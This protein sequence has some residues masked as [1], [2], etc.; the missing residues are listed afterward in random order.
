VP[1]PDARRA[2][3]KKYY[4]Q[5]APTYDSNRYG[6]D[7]QRR[8]DEQAKSVVLE[9]LGDRDIAASRVL[10]C[11]CGTGRFTQLF[12][13]L[14]SEVVG[15][16]ASPQMIDIARKKVPKASFQLGDIFELPFKKEFDI[17]VSSQV[18]T[19]L[20]EYQ[21][22]LDGMLRA[23]RPG[24]TIV[25]DVRN[26]LSPRHALRALR[27]RA[28]NLLGKKLDYEPHFTTLAAMRR[29]GERIGLRVIDWRG[30]GAA[31][32][33]HGGGRFAPTLVIRFE[34]A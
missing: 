13:S 14:G 22:P 27:N 10:D 34:P 19:H 29:T 20:H 21:R 9:L 28:Q 33:G 3:V 15:F 24:G 8:L 17:V 2:H 18:L 16:D 31:G 1:K 7:E 23:L 25:V 30:A 6:N 5:F 12:D 26:L 11:G 4:D 32:A